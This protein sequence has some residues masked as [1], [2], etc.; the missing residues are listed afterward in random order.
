MK[1]ERHSRP[2]MNVHL[3][4]V[5]VATPPYAA[6]QMEAE[7]FLTKNYGQRLS[8]RSQSALHT[9][10]SHPS[11]S[12]RHFAVDQYGDM[13][14]EDPDHRIERFTR[15]GIQLSSQAITQALAE[16]GATTG[17]ISAL[18][19][20]TCT[21][22]IC[23][24]L[25][26]YLIE[27][28]GL[29][30]DLRVYDLVGSGCV[31]ALPNLEVAASTLNGSPD[32]VVVSVSVEICSTTLQMGDDLSLLVSNTI[33]GDG[34]A[35]AVVSRRPG[36]LALIDSSR[37]HAPEHR[38]H[39]RYVYKHGQLHNQLSVEL[40]GLAAKAAAAAVGDL[41]GRQGLTAKDVRHWALHPGGAK[42]IDAVRDEMGLSAQQVQAS[43]DVLAQYGNMSSAT[44]WFVLRT[45][46]DRGM[47]P[48][49][50]C[51]MVSFGAGLSANALLLRA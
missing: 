43:R 34:A 3:A 41:L 29:A 14:D 19:V 7:A 38:D 33:F 22:Y 36:G 30:R 24:G 1:D 39:I 12:R 26:T 10:F 18:V 8:E 15:W 51:L 45:L 28:L 13:I 17:S 2:S 46:L 21:G 16:A 37:R 4:S 11:V 49:D 25:S 50:W 32:G 27:R 5:A 35:A 44:V 6:D 48:G 40:P 42:I 31:G 9:L 47:D 23:P 20:N